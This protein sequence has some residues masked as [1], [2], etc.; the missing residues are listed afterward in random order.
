MLKWIRERL[1]IIRLIFR[2]PILLAVLGAAQLGALLFR[3]VPRLPEPLNRLGVLVEIPWYGW[4]IGWLAAFWLSTI[5]YS[6]QRKKRFDVTSANFFKAYLD[7]LIHEGNKLFDYSDER[8]FYSKINEWKHQA[9]QGIAIG[10]G[11]EASKKF[12]QKM[13]SQNPLS[14]AYRKSTADH[15]NEALCRSLQDHLEELN[16]MRMELNDKSRPPELG[17]T[18]ANKTALSVRKSPPQPPTHPGQPLL[19]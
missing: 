12:F 6:V 7:F 3:F 4:V 8:D 9:I 17:E 10:L 2:R 15:S 13:E 19:P 1:E 5:E 16:S 14:E 18:E 11:P